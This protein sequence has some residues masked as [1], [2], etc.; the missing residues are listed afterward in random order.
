MTQLGGMSLSLESSR[1]RTIAGIAE[2]VSDGKCD[3]DGRK[4][5][6]LRV[7]L[8]FHAAETMDEPTVG[9][10]RTRNLFAEAKASYWCNRLI[11]GY[12]KYVLPSLLPETVGKQTG[13]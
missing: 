6:P 8:P 12:K 11:W 13:D 4:T 2:L 7:A 10:L 9:R 3:R 1:T 5:A